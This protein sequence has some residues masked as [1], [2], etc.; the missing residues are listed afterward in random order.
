[1][2][3]II[4]SNLGKEITLHV[5]QCFRNMEYTSLKPTALQS[6]L[7]GVPIWPAAPMRAI[8]VMLWVWMKDRLGML[9]PID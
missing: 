4:E 3:K 6:R 5:C 9:N 1:M 2:N 7:S 8:L